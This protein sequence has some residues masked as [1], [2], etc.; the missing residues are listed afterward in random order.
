ME[1]RS[2]QRLKRARVAV[3]YVEPSEDE[4]TERCSRP[5]RTRK[6][7]ECEKMVLAV[8]KGL[9]WTNDDGTKSPL[10]ILSVDMIQE[11][12][13]RATRSRLQTVHGEILEKGDIVHM[14][15][16][17]CTILHEFKP[18]ITTLPV[19]KVT[20]CDMGGLHLKAV[21]WEIHHPV[22]PFED[23]AKTTLKASHHHK[24][25][26]TLIKIKWQEIKAMAWVR[27]KVFVANPRLC[28]GKSF[29]RLPRW[30]V[31]NTE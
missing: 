29:P 17:E 9:S 16:F 28:A 24:L 27:A 22:D 23:G 14:K 8:A 5:T 6:R 26:D 31:D 30:I 11:L 12:L 25:Y 10:S 2:G 1:S 15:I 20:K 7:T 13:L 3:S 21:E 18:D 4:F 19:F